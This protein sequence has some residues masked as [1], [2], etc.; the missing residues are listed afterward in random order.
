[1]TRGLHF[2]RRADEEHLESDTELRAGIE[3]GLGLLGGDR[4]QEFGE[5]QFE[6]GW[7]KDYARNHLPNDLCQ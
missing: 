3:D 6:Q 2:P 7:P 1:M 4:A 5:E